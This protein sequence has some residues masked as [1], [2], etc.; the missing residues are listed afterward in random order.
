MRS[1]S[2]ALDAV[3]R[4]AGYLAGALLVLLCGLILWSILARLLNLYAGGASDVA[5][6]VMAG[7]TFLALPYAF[8]AGAHIRVQ[9]LV[10]TLSGTPARRAVE[11]LV[12]AVMSTVSVFLAWYMTRLA[13]DSWDFGERSQGADAILIWIPQAPV[14]AGAWLFAVSVIH[15]LVQAIFDYDAV[16]PDTSKGASEP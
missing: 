2:H 14:A 10:Q 6:Y 5:G 16:D 15:T 7:G 1:L 4:V 3:Y 9:L 8:R 12:L 13:Y 11:I